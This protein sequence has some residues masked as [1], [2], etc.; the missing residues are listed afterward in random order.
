[1]AGMNSPNPPA[2]GGLGGLWEDC[3]EAAREGGA[4]G[5]ARLREGW[6]GFRTF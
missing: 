6:E 3:P 1:M 2:M 4:K 5:A